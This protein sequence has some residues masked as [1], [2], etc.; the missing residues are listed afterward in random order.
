MSAIRSYITAKSANITAT[1]EDLNKICDE[2]NL[3]YISLN[4]Y[5]PTYMSS[6]ELNITDNDYKTKVVKLPA[7]KEV[8]VEWIIEKVNAMQ[9]TEKAYINL[10]KQFKKVIA[11]ID[12]M[13][14]YPT[15]YGIGIHTVFTQ[16]DSEFKAILDILDNNDIE[17]RLEWSDAFWVKRI[18]ISKTKENIE[19]INQFKA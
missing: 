5:D 18:I 10:S 1:V 13:S 3:Q 2:Y 11:K 17:Y 19:R 4:E 12:N 15:S 8:S 16:T 14:I 6:E 9:N 7:K